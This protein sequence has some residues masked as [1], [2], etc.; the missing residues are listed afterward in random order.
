MENRTFFDIQEEQKEQA[1]Q[2]Q[3]GQLDVVKM[4]FLGAEAMTWQELFS[5][6]DT[7]HAITYS[8]G[9]GFVCDLL[10]N[11]KSA[12]I[13]FGCDEVM[14]YSMQEVMAY[15]CKLIERIRESAGRKKA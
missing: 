11:F 13:L 5:G 4:E 12:E 1:A 9:T 15:Q 14:S 6:F 8:S 2:K 3:A 10:Q 7:L